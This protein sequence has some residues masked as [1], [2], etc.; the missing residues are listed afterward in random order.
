MTRSNSVTHHAWPGFQPDGGLLLA[1]TPSLHWLPGSSSLALDGQRFFAKREL[2]VTLLNGAV[3]SQLRNRLGVDAVR[4]HFESQDW[5]IARTSEGQL[6]HKIK[7]DGPQPVLCGSIIERLY[8]PALGR[9]RSALARAAK[10]DVPE[11][12][13]HVT[14]YVAGDPGGIGLPDL[15]AVETAHL[16]YVRLPG[17]CNR[18]PPRLSQALIA[19]Y[20]AAH[21]VIR[22]ETP[23]TLRIGQRSTAME[24]LLRR[25][26]ASRAIVVT[27]FNPFSEATDSRA[28]SLRQ[29]MLVHALAD[30]G[31]QVLEAEGRDTEG[32]WP[33]EPSLLVFATEPAFEDR[34][35][36]D[37][38]QHAIVVITR[39]E[40]VALALHP[41]HR[42]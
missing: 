10:M 4:C 37:Y 14:L 16:A 27:A 23:I 25:N 31:L 26:V 12:L 36:R 20:R 35:L 32:V 7:S 2:H 3:G 5:A 22:D 28:N 15:A 8:L 13:P 18:V 41:D 1:L 38:E 29:Q 6:L 17:I 42:T 30:E 40:P 9:F 33:P 39:G 21:Y 34:L 11:V 19:V 24:E